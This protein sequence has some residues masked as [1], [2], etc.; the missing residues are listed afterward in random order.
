MK[1][2]IRRPTAG[3]KVSRRMSLIDVGEEGLQKFRK[4]VDDP[5]SQVLA[6]LD[7]DH[8]SRKLL[9]HLPDFLSSELHLSPA[10]L[11]EMIDKQGG[12]KLCVFVTGVAA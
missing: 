1:P 5:Q 12:E 11:D 10:L 8:L 7:L 4:A 2:I 6:K 9:A 3:H